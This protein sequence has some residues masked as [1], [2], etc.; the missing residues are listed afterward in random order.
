[1]HGQTIPFVS[2]G[3]ATEI[4]ARDGARAV[5]AAGRQVHAWRV[6]LSPPTELGPREPP[7]ST[8]APMTL[9][10]TGMAENRSGFCAAS[11][12]REAPESQRS[13]GRLPRWDRGP[14]L[15]GDLRECLHPRRAIFEEAAL[16]IQPRILSNH[17]RMKPPRG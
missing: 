7:S 2:R 4:L 16:E 15:K 6:T 14:R 13:R 10:N 5:T 17:A 12:G 11:E 8:G 3:Y 1:M 9:R